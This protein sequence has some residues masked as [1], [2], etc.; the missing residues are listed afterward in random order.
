MP[1]VRSGDHAEESI[2]VRIQLEGRLAEE[3]SGWLD[4]FSLSYIDPFG[5][6]PHTV[7]I[8]SIPDQAALRGLLNKIWNMNLAVLSVE[9]FTTAR[10]N[11][12]LELPDSE[13]NG[14]K[15]K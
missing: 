9:C 10:M 15:M 5:N 14:S 12:A 1:L 6:A 13:T 7:L 8:G 2:M 4:A 3:W 11:Q